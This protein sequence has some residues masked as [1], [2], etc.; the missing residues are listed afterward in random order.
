MKWPSGILQVTAMQ[1]SYNYQ[2]IKWPDSKELH[3]LV[4][5][6]EH[7]QQGETFMLKPPR[8]KSSTLSH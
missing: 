1:M 8:G 7:P 6:L 3:T 5:V 2:S 4:Y